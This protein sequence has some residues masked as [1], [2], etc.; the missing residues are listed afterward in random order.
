MPSE[1]MELLVSALSCSGPA[2]PHLD[3]LIRLLI[4]G[5]KFAG[6]VGGKVRRPATRSWQIWRE[7]HFPCKWFKLMRFDEK[8]RL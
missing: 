2:R 3:P 5:C 4:Q 1:L 7:T 6:K 8:K